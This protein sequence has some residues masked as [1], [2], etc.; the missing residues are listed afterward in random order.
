MLR[1]KRRIFMNLEKSIVDWSKHRDSYTYLCVNCLQDG[2]VIDMCDAC[3]LAMCRSCV[4]ARHTGPPDHRLFC[5]PCIK[6]TL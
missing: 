1:L 6:G 4:D 3:N 5:E 2:A